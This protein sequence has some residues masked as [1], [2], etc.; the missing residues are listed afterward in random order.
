M[1]GRSKPYCGAFVG[2]VLTQCN[3]MQGLLKKIN[4][5]SVSSW[6]TLS[7]WFVPTA[8]AQ[9]GDVVTYRSWSHVGFVKKWPKDPRIPIFFSVDGNSSAGRG[10]EGVHTN[11]SRAKSNVRH[12]IRVIR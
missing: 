9:P 11:I 1:A 5:A 3:L 4:M 7:S 10:Q 2:W 8:Q 12:V 6:N